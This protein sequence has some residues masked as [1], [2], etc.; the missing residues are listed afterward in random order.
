[1]STE[2]MEN[3]ALRV[4]LFDPTGNITALVESAVA[5]AARA[6]AAA[7][8]MERFPQ[9]EQVGF[10]RLP[11]CEAAPVELCMAGGEFCGNASMSA[12][13]LSLMRRG[14][15]RGGRE[16]VSLRVAGVADAVEV[17]L[18]RETEDRF[19]AAVRMPSPL[20]FGE[21]DFAFRA[22]RGRI[23]VV[24][25]EGIAHALIRPDS[26]FFAL[27]EDAP[28]AAEALKAQCA[29]LGAE[30]MGWLF[31]EE[32]APGLRFTPLVYVPLS[33]TVC[34]ERSCASGSAAVAAA[35]AEERGER[36]SLTLFEPGGVMLA[37]SGGL[38]GETRL[39]GSTRLV[40]EAIV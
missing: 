8:V 25:M 1:M 11:A 24:R 16:T 40:G 17:S 10:V 21:E 37:E 27:R 38:R 18:R 32:E 5:P 34:W 7:R 4:S 19:F 12:A 26:V 29:A 6:A 28:A 9:A 30:A 35:L 20:A 2:S 31:L 22:L 36:V 13:A 15:P 14:L 33:G 39:H 23:P 3:R